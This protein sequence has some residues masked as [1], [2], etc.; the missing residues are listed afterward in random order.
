MWLSCPNSQKFYQRYA[1]SAHQSNKSAR[2]TQDSSLSSSID[3]S[4]KTIKPSGKKSGKIFWSIW[5]ITHTSKLSSLSDKDTFTFCNISFL[6][7]WKAVRDVS[8]EAWRRLNSSK[9]SARIWRHQRLWLSLTTEFWN[10]SMVDS[11][12]ERLRVLPTAKYDQYSFDFYLLI[13]VTKYVIWEVSF[14]RPFY[15]IEV[16]I[17]IILL[18]NERQ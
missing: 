18:S 10:I 8:T 15:F 3:C 13:I 11:T 5:S 14:F 1:I 7:L 17:V 16:C 12:K 2:N 4:N 9:T 6:R